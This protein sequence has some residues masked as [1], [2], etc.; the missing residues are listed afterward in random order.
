MAW[1][2]KFVDAVSATPTTLLDLNNADSVSS[3]NLAGTIQVDGDN[4]DFGWPELRRSLSSSTLADGEWVSTDSYGNRTL[5]IPLFLFGNAAQ[6]S[7]NITAIARRLNRRRALLMVQPE[8]LNT[9]IF[10]RTLRSSIS[11][12]DIRDAGAGVWRL[13]LSIMAE[14]FG[15]GLQESF[16][17]SPTNTMA[18]LKQTLPTIKGD[19]A[20]V[21]LEQA[22]HSH[23]LRDHA[24]AHDQSFLSEAHGK[25]RA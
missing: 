24:G 12:S 17:L 19:V 8:D 13:T 16:N 18:N 23:L 10:F 3:R 11:D 22:G 6:V 1:I 4:F 20:A 14:P 7:A 15:W 25:P 2:C 5:R 9:P 21:I